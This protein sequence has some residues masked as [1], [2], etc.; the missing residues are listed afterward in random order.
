MRI[1]EPSLG[2]ADKAYVYN[3]REKYDHILSTGKIT[4]QELKKSY[5]S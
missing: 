4:D 2:L 3:R 1:Y 5:I